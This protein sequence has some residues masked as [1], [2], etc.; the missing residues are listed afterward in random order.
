MNTK[1]RPLTIFLA[2]DNADDVEI[3]RRAFK[4]CDIASRLIVARDGEEALRL[5]TDSAKTGAAD[6]AILDIKLPRLNGLEVLSRIRKDPALAALP[7][8]MLSASAHEEDIARSYRLGA[9][10]YIQKPVA[11]EVFVETLDTLCH[12]WFEVAKLPRAA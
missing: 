5:L 9:N 4:K 12:Y 6:L 7:V 8:I 11:F 1:Y 10:T 2:E 3:T